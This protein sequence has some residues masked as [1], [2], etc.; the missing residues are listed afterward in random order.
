MVISGSG[1]PDIERLLPVACRRAARPVVRVDPLR[2]RAR[3]P[4]P[5]RRRLLRDAVALRAVRPEPALRHAVRDAADRAR[6]RRARGHRDDL[7]RGV[8]RGN[9]L[10]ASRSPRRQPGR[11]DRLGGVD[12]VRPPG[13][14]RQRCDAGRWH[15]TIPGIDPRASTSTCTSKRMRVGAGMPSRLRPSV[16]RPIRRGRS[17]PLVTVRQLSR[18]NESRSGGMLA[19]GVSTATHPASPLALRRRARAGLAQSPSAMPSERAVAPPRRRAARTS[20][21]RP[22]ASIP[23]R[24]RR[25]C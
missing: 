18:W 23:A 22:P 5:G 25:P 2:R 20:C 21:A 14:H 9:G 17:S 6:D 8:R 3:T 16:G 15:E 13:A 12:L 4:H 1:D 11:H 24:H 10:R 19:R 7:R